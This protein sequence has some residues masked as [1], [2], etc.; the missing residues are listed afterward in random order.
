M[1]NIWGACDGIKLKIQEPQTFVKQEPLYNGWTHRNYVNF[2]FV[3][4]LLMEGFK[5]VASI[6]YAVGMIVLK[7]TTTYIAKW[8]MH[9]ILMEV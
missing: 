4:S 6:L 5:F 3:L 1:G 2:T 7:L 8:K 9:S